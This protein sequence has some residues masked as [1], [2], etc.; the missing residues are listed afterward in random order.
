MY[1]NKRFI[2]TVIFF[3]S[4]CKVSF[5]NENLNILFEKLN[6]AKDLKTAEQVEKSIWNTW[7]THPHNEYLTNKL[8]NATYSMN[9]RQYQ[10]ALKLF[11]DVIK[12]D[13]VWAEAWNKR[14]TLLFIMGN[15]KESLKD[16]EK[17]LNL[18]PRHFGALSGRAQIY[19]SFREY[20]KA[21]NDLERAKSIYPMIKS[22]ESIQMIKNLIKELQ[23]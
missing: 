18:E 16:I 5:A 12:E 19:L 3:V 6:A 13:P 17:V 8:E 22:A 7:I 15:Y 2:L 9:N 21:I 10:L 11:T 23:I 20:E 14:A 1:L 4:L